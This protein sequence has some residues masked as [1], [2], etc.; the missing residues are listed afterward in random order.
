MNILVINSGSSSIKLSVF[1][2]INEEQIFKSQIARSSSIE[3]DMFSIPQALNKITIDAIGHRV[4][5]GGAKF[6]NSVVIDESVKEAI[7]S[8][9]IIAPLHNFSALA[10]IEISQK[11]WPNLPQIAVFDTGFHQFMPP[12]AT[13]YAVPK[14]WRD[15]GLKRYGFHGISHQY[16]MEKVAEE[17]KTS[18]VDLRIISCHLGN[19]ASICAID[20]GISVDNSMGMTVLEGLVM[21]TRSGDVDPGIFDYLQKNLGLSLEE[22]EDA[23]YNKSGLLALSEISDDMREIEKKLAM[24]VKMPNW[25]LMFMPI[26]S[27]NILVLML[28]Q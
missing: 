10:E 7:K 17:L 4:V 8:A 12:K 19:G 11:I 28:R 6:Y 5:H 20:R 1:R 25:Q 23:L 27:V 24:V 15:A 18:A 26:V 13:T 9:I 3:N 21:G 16:V 2:V 22:I 14:Q